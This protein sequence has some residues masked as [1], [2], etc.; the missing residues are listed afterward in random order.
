MKVATQRIPQ[1]PHRE[2]TAMNMGETAA[3]RT[4]AVAAGKVLRVGDA[5]IQLEFTVLFAER[6]CD[7]PLVTSTPILSLG[8]IRVVLV[9]FAE[10]A[11]NIQRVLVAMCR[12]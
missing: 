6:I 11:Q 10:I 5:L 1:G 7:S 3:S 8:A 2:T 4:A 12:G 9:A